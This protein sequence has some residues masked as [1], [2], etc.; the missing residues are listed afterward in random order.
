MT[1]KTTRITFK[2]GGVRETWDVPAGWGKRYRSLA[3]AHTTPEVLRDLLELIGY[4][5][6][7]LAIATWPLRRRV[8]LL[9]YA[10]NVHLR[11]SDNPIPRHPRLEGLPDPWTGKGAGLDAT[12]TPLTS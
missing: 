11:A 3:L 7:P 1:A 5:A 4:T 8:E 10:S 6:D 9:V 2:V 12:P